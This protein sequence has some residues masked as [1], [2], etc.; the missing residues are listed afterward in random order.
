MTSSFLT[1]AEL[2]AVGFAAIGQGVLIDRTALWFGAERIRI[3]SHTRVDAYCVIQAGE[4]GVVLGDYVH[5]ATGVTIG[6]AA[7][8]EIGDFC[9][10]S[11]GVAIFSSNDDY[12]RGA[13][14][15]PMVPMEYRNVTSARV[16][17]EKHVIVGS[18]SVIMPGVS[19]GTGA[20]VGALSFV[21]KPVPE[22]AI[23]F[24]NPLRMIGTRDRSVLER[25]RAFR[26][27]QKT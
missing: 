20:S 13:M 27:Q 7:G 21:H 1:A 4:G 10:L 2:E 25:E 17:L 6:G 18:G 5:L 22:F 11:R 19:I 8:V 9:G 24:G 15:N 26:T 23:A 3:G 12:T 16:R 14:T